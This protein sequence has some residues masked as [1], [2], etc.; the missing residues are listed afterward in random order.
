M[1]RT[2]YYGSSTPAKLPRK[3]ADMSMEILQN[4][5]RLH[6]SQAILR[7]AIPTNDGHRDWPEVE[8]IVSDYT[9]IHVPCLILWGAHDDTLPRSTGYRLQMEIPEGRLTIIPKSK[10]ALT[11][12]QP[13]LYASIIREFLTS[14]QTVS[15]EITKIPEHRLTPTWSVA[16][17]GQSPETKLRGVGNSL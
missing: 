2:V 12:E 6:A 13:L 14:D 16:G 11:V 5:D 4:V 7:Q 9:N 17:R 15:P 10:H 1:A 3:E 8:R